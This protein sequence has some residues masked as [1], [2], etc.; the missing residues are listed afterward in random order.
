MP[1]HFITQRNPIAV[2]SH[3]PPH[4][5]APPAPGNYENDFPSLD[6]PV[7]GISNDTMCGLSLKLQRFQGSSVL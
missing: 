5:P 6:L 2:S 7:W 4:P 1:E 3:F